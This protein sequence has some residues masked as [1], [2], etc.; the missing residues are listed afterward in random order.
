[1]PAPQPAG[2]VSR[3][4]QPPARL[5]PGQKAKKTVC[6][7]H[8]ATY[9]FLNQSFQPL[10][11]FKGFQRSK[12]QKVE[13][14]F[15]HSLSGLSKRYGLAIRTSREEPFPFN[16]LVAFQNAKKQLEKKAHSTDLIITEHNGKTTL[17]TI[18][19]IGIDHTLYYTSLNALDWLHQRKDLPTF[20]L[21]LSI[22]AYLHQTVGMPL[23]AGNDFLSG[24]YETIADW[25][26][27]SKKEYE[28]E[29][30]KENSRLISN[31]RR[32]RPIL[33]KAVRNPANLAAFAGRL[34]S[35]Q[36]A[37]EA[38]E[39]FKKLATGFWILQQ[40]YPG[41]SFYRNIHSDHIEE[42]DEDCA[43]PDQYFSFFWDDDGWLYESLMEY[44]NCDLQERC[45]FVQPVAVNYFHT[46]K[47]KPLSDLAFEKSLLQHCAELYSITYLLTK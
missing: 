44:I 7:T 6:S 8:H 13:E 25:L 40:Q 9:A 18:E 32:K 30:W 2:Q 4:S 10:S 11:H 31:M 34:N 47:P 41:L 1:M 46:T 15:F 33:E 38:E 19:Q 45:I 29:E 22:Y 14:A 16:I 5:R 37:N 21:M 17:A 43:W 20:S 3:Q 36:P 23:L 24:C 42:P 28:E 27:N 26:E 12:T 35:Y 39:Q